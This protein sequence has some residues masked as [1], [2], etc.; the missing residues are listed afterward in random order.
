MPLRGLK[1]QNEHRLQSDYFKY[2]QVT[3]GNHTE[4]S[5][6]KHNNKCLI[7]WRTTIKR[8]I[9]KKEPNGNSELK[10]NNN[11]NEN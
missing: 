8:E 7:K 9:I 2:V 3:K 5:K 4:R 11:W 1:C 10:K 6:G